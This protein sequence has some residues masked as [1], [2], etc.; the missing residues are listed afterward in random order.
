[1]VA[2]W[3]SVSKL[4]PSASALESLGD[5]SGRVVTADLLS[6]AT[7]HKTW[8]RDADKTILSSHGAQLD[9]PLVC[10]HLPAGTNPHVDT[11]MHSV[12]IRLRAASTASQFPH[13]FF[14]GPR[15]DPATSI[16]RQ[17]ILGGWD[18]AASRLG[19]KS[20][21]RAAEFLRMRQ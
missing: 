18:C 9:L 7:C 3:R 17:Q 11:N 16:G 6:L 1:M 10:H 15:S 13:S 21:D 5:L 19:K 12:S 14:E 20:L 8:A 2:T 4:P